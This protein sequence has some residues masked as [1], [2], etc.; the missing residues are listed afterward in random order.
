MTRRVSRDDW[1]PQQ[2]MLSGVT[3]C[4]QPIERQRRLTR[5]CMEVA[6]EAR[7]PLSII[8]K[9]AL[10]LRDLDLLR[11]L[12]QAKQATV[13]QVALRWVIDQGALPIP[14]AKNAIQAKENA[15]TL[16]VHLTADECERLAQASAAWCH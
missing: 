6:L 9:N 8:T 13:S 2:I 5:G 15:H 10:I 4:Y 7:Q 16:G 1:S 3:D 12:A 14:G 11:E